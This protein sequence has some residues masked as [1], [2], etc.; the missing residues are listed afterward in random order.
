MI[1]DFIYAWGMSWWSFHWC[2]L[3]GT[4]RGG[5][6]PSLRSGFSRTPGW[7][8]VEGMSGSRNRGLWIG[9]ASVA[10]A[11]GLT[12]AGLAVLRDRGIARRPRAADYSGLL[13][14]VKHRLATIPKSEPGRMKDVLSD[15]RSCDL[16]D[17]DLSAERQALSEASFDSCT[18]W[19]EKIPPGFDPARVLEKG[20]DPGLQI[21]S[22]HRRGIDGRG[23]AIAIID[24]V[25]LVGHREYRSRL[26]RYEEIN[27]GDDGAS[28]HGPSMASMAVGRS[29]GVAPAAT[30][31]FVA[32]RPLTR[33]PEGRSGAKTMFDFT[34][35][36]R[37]VDRVVEINGTLPA[38][39]RI[40]ALSISAGWSPDMKGYAEMT[41]AVDRARRS[42]LFVISCNSFETY[43]EGFYFQPLERD[44]ALDQDDFSSYT[45]IPWSRSLH[46]LSKPPSALDRYYGERFDGWS[47]GSV[48]LVPINSRSS[49]SPT[50]PSD[51]AYFREGGWSMVPPFLAGLYALAC[52]VRPDITPELFWK[53]AVATGV[54]LAPQENAK[55]YDGRIIHPD[56]LL[57]TLRPTG[58]TWP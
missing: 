34:S 45:I 25:L 40:R 23:V 6:A 57:A 50:G 51:Y 56:R 10:A 1:Q 35:D 11:L 42:G 30:L 3:G 27:C 48:L 32:A 15:L 31:Y 5:A 22:L 18:L 13:A 26:R 19:P 54:A 39:K 12:V 53:T 36:A 58:P 24:D 38:G 47:G 9:A 4:R 28:M 37:A 49:A 17:F 2:Q 21:R 16:R 29:C 55:T 46:L 20:K 33:N 8:K 52:Q 44:P 43:A 7:D 41:A 14:L